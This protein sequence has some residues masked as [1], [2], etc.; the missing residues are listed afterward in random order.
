MRNPG[1][2]MPK[3]ERERTADRSRLAALAR[4]V[5]SD[6]GAALTI[7]LG[8]IGDRLGIFR[9]MADGT[10]LDSAELAAYT[11]LNE[12]YLREW[13]STM[14]AAGYVEYEAEHGKFRLSPEQAI[15]LADERSTFFGAGA[16][17]YAVACYR[18]IPPLADAF[19]NGGGVPFS[20]YGEDIVSAI[21]RM[22]QAGYEA[23]VA[24]QWIPA[25]PDIHEKM[26]A[27][28]EA[29]EVGCGAGQCLIPVA[30]AFPK[31]RF[32]GFDVD[33]TSIGRAREKA[34]EA[35]LSDRVTFERIA[36]E[37]LPYRDRF[38]LVMAFNCIHDMA[39]PRR[40][41]AAVCRA[42]RPGA[43][44]LWSEA[45]A[46]DRLAD[47]LNPT[48]RSMYAASTMH[49]MT[50]SLAGGG[51]GLGVVVGERRAR[52]MALE[53]GFSGFTRLPVENP[54]HQIFALRR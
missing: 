22:F 8:F 39:F 5:G 3:D 9:A 27:G 38:D 24:S 15:V 48:G 41:L 43:V 2:V 11:G 53:A 4:Q 44:M 35:G 32:F 51:E 20:A 34:K 45:D 37:Q 36:A 31:S 17:Q 49:C 33:A 54:Y 46:S 42:L 28:G 21:E 47:N 29:A 19:K 40:V 26:Q 13:L 25:V 10:A 23:W 30:R 16:F 52:E 18:Q 50:V 6:F 1:E 7:A 12:R 14:A